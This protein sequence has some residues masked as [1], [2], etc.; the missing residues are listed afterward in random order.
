MRRSRRRWRASWHGI[1][2]S[3]YLPARVGRLESVDSKQGDLR[4]PSWCRLPKYP[5]RKLGT[6]EGR[7]A[8]I[9][10]ISHIE[11]NAINLALDAAYRFVGLPSE[12]YADWV[13]IAGEEALHFSLLSTHLNE[14]GFAYGDFDAHN[15]LWQMALDTAHDPAKF[16]WRSFRVF[17]KRG[18][19]M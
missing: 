18:D 9:H 11:F 3:L 4:S 12:Y 2:S 5:Q 1:I 10:A 8:L 16:E 7:A 15:G 14:L 19:W 6:T 13:R 17:W